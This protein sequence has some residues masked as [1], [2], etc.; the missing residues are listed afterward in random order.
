MR[1][2]G[3]EKKAEVLV[4]LFVILGLCIL[5]AGIFWGKKGNVFSRRIYLTVRF[6]DVR[7]LVPGDPVMVRGIQK[8]EVASMSLEPEYARVR[9]WIEN[10]VRLF[11]DLR[12]VLENRDIMGAKQLSL[13]PGRS[14]I[15]ADQNR[16][17]EGVRSGDLDNMLGTFESV[18]NRVD[19]LVLEMREIL[20][21]VNIG[22]TLNH[23]EKTVSEAG[24]LVSEN[25]ANLKDAVDRFNDLSRRMAEDSVV[26]RF[27]NTLSLIDTSTFQLER[28]LQAAG[29]S[30]TLGKLVY[31]NTLHE[32]IV[33]TAARLDSLITDIR[34]HPKKFLHFSVF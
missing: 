28:L 13:K 6:A 30:G 22:S 8:G 12:V 2:A 21:T 31:D 5:V 25:R 29:G 26:T 17:F 27:M 7:G 33:Q 11:S 3:S 15:A 18:V 4:G 9:F 20:G 19:T 16:V 1:V 14:R 32:Q 34:Q 23:L 24:L 10:D